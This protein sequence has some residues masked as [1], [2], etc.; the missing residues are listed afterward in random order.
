MNY[1]ESNNIFTLCC[2]VMC[3]SVIFFISNLA[4]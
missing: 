1:H 3:D 2:L 4:Q